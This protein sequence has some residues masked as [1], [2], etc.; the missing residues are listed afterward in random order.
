MRRFDFNVRWLPTV[1]GNYCANDD[2]FYIVF[3][4]VGK[5]GKSNNC[6]YSADLSILEH[7]IGFA[8]QNQCQKSEYKYEK[9]VN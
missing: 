6:F 8:H 3:L 7:R 5:Q 4:K 9:M 2:S 1:N